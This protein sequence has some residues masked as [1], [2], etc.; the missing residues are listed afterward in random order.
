LT[1]KDIDTSIAAASSSRNNAVSGWLVRRHLPGLPGTGKALPPA[2]CMN[3]QTV[4]LQQISGMDLL[5][6]VMDFASQHNR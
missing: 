1:V 4:K 2:R 5:I 6:Q 3:R